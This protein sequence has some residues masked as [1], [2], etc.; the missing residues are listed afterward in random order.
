[1]PRDS[2]VGPSKPLLF[3]FISGF[4]STLIFHQLVLAFLWSLAIAPFRPFV[5]APTRPLGI[6]AVFSLA[7]WGGIWGIVLALF[8]SRL[9]RR[10]YWLVLF[11]FGAVFPS[12]VAFLV[13]LPM[14][15]RPMGGGW[16]PGLLMTAFLINGAWGVGTGLFLKFL[17]RSSTRY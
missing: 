9:P 2:S 4:L 5:M 15:G 11:L 14:K 10:G 8:E 16:H 6:P 1:M 17:S 7:F 12:F 13:V 3:G